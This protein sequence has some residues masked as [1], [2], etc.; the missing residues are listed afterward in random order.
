MWDDWVAILPQ[1]EDRVFVAMARR[2]ETSYGMASVALDEALSVREHGRLVPA[3]QLAAISATLIQHLVA[4]LVSALDVVEDQARHLGALPVVEPLNPEFFRSEKARSSASWNHLLFRVLFGE[5]TRFFHKLRSLSTTLDGLAE[6]FADAAED[7]AGGTC[8]QP[9]ESWAALER[10]H[11]DVNTCLREA[12]V[13][14][15]SLLRTLPPKQL[16]AFEEK[17]LASIPLPSSGYS[18]PRPSRVPA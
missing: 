4:V 18:Q 8:I 10:L 17:L 5:R 12:V 9:G 1:E 3:R 15:K 14:L 11:Y 7:I 13:L 16:A 2:W 6:E